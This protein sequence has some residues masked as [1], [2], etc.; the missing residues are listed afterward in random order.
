MHE[1]A[2][3]LGMHATTVSR[4]VAGKYLLSPQ[5]LTEMRAFFATGYQ[6]DDGSEVSNTGVREAS[7][8]T[9]RQRKPHPN[10]SP[11]KPS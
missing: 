8:T 10:P 5:G 9:R 2:E 7:P 4:A 6:T 1:I 3:A 11:T